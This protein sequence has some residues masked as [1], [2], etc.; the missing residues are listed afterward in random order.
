MEVALRPVG[1]GGGGGRTVNGTSPEEGLSTR[2][3]VFEIRAR[4]VVVPGLTAS[5]ALLA[6][7]LEL[8]EATA[9]L[10]LDQVYLIVVPDG[11]TSH[12]GNAV[13]VFDSPGLAVVTPPTVSPE[14]MYVVGGT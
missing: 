9:G 7:I 2:T 6:V 8:T 11:T 14:A 3:P 10:V 5:T 1:G 12:S 13:S 4:M